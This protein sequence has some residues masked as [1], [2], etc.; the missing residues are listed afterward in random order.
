MQGTSGIDPKLVEKIQKLENLREGAEA[1]GSM[2]EAENAAMRIQELLFKHNLTMDQVSATKIREKVTMMQDKFDL[3]PH[4]AK[5]EA[6]WLAKLIFAISPLFM[7]QAVKTTTR[8]HRYDQGIMT[9]LGEKNNVAVVIY[10]VEQLINKIDVAEKMEWKRYAG[11]EKR[12]TF[13][14][15]FLVGAV[16]GIT[17]KL[18]AQQEELKRENNSLALMVINKQKEVEKFTQEVFP[19][20]KTARAAS[21]MS[22]D[23]RSSGYEA[24]RNMNINRGV[25]GGNS[26]S[27][28]KL[29]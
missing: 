11:H 14:R 1:I 7:C 23:G 8:R 18:R 27:T 15:G 29:N 20:L 2:A 9:I 19:R 3:D 5:T 10:T 6:D 28:R 25:G 17:S 22:R 4:Q 24:G 21:L 26:G 13:R 12:N 16:A